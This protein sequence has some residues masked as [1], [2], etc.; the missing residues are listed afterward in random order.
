MYIT[1]YLGTILGSSVISTTA[2]GDDQPVSTAVHFQLQHRVQVGKISQNGT[3]FLKI[4]STIISTIYFSIKYVNYVF[5]ILYR[6]PLVL[7]MIQCVPSGI[8]ISSKYQWTFLKSMG[9]VD[10]SDFSRIPQLSY[11]FHQKKKMWWMQ[12]NF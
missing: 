3:I 1:R 2:L 12:Q 11:L 7:C 6:I 8:L 5:C 4:N 9:N 10:F